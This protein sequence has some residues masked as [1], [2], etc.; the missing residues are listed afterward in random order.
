MKL[1]WFPSIITAALIILV[2]Q[3]CSMFSQVPKD[4]IPL[5]TTG[6]KLYVAKC[7]GCHELYSPAT[8][9]AKE[10]SEIVN[11]MQVRAKITDYEKNL[12][13]DYLKVNAKK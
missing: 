5:P 1:G 9:T 7:G 12:I 4:N 3:G 2:W 10:W 8:Y 6:E 13:N 11:E